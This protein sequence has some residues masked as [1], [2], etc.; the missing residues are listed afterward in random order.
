M[1]LPSSVCFCFLFLIKRK[2]LF[3]LDLLY[4]RALLGNLSVF[5]IELIL[6]SAERRVWQWGFSTASDFLFFF[7][8]CFY[9]W[10]Q[11]TC[12]YCSVQLLPGFI[13]A[14]WPEGGIAFRFPVL[15]TSVVFAKFHWFA[16]NGIFI[17]CGFCCF[18]IYSSV[19]VHYY[20][21][22]FSKV[23][24]SIKLNIARGCWDGM[25]DFFLLFI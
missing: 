13:F 8:I 16:W 22:C 23:C 2:H 4:C 21:D 15:Y 24:T 19:A 18:F 25:R 1:P 20:E 12:I 10:D 9:I 14:L 5:G 7:L 3:N 17:L 11:I 6:S